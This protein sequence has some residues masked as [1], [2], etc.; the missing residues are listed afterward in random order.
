MT[1]TILGSVVVN[2]TKHYLRQRFV[3]FTTTGEFAVRDPPAPVI[4]PRND[5]PFGG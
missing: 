3:Q 4:T 2:C 1:C 5:P